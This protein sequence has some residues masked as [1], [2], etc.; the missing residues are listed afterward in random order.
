MLSIYYTQ[1]S[2]HMTPQFWEWCKLQLPLN[3]CKKIEQRLSKSKM[4]TS[5]LGYLL[6]K[7]VLAKNNLS[8][9]IAQLYYTAE[10][11]PQIGLDFDFNISHSDDYVVCAFS[12]HHHVGIDI[13]KIKPISLDFLE[14]FFN[15]DEWTNIQSSRDSQKTFYKL[16]TKKEATVKAD[17]RGLNIPL[18]EIIIQNN[19]G[20]VERA[21]WYLHEIPLNQKY[22][23][24]L[25]TNEPIQYYQSVKIS[26]KQICQYNYDL[27]N[28][29]VSRTN[30]IK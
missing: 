21:K 19:Q 8:D 12:K 6:L 30:S 7:V 1:K 13:E 17:G 23:M 14:D 5:L 26:F 3:I 4:Q 15:V 29:K 2:L 9:D 22:M 27:E 25:A 10:G 18:K 16:W 20:Y 28:T 11:R 24:H